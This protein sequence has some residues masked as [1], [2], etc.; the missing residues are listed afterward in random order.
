MRTTIARASTAVILAVLGAGAA[1]A[2]E[3]PYVGTWSLDPANCS[4]GQ[5]S[6][7]APMVIG[8]DRYDQHE[9]HCTFKSVEAKNSDWT[10][11]SECTVEGSATPYEFTLTVSG[12]TLTFTDSNG[13]R[14]LLRC[15]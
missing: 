13:G 2:A 15:K 14:D 1:I 5:E 11:K 6:Q 7:S 12:D 10:V 3:P 9:S 4:Q 8:K